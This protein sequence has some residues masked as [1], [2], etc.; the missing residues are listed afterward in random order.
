MRAELV[1]TGTELLLGQVVNTNA[2]FL[3][4][5]LA[6]LGI[7][8]YRVTTVGDNLARLIRALRNAQE[9]ADLVFIGGG[10]G[11]TQDDLTREAVAEA[12][13]TR[14]Y[15]NEAAKQSILDFFARR[16]SPCP[17]AN[18]KQ[19]L[20]PEGAE[21]IPNIYG[22]APGF[23]LTAKDKTLIA[24][25][26]PPKEFQAMLNQY[27][28]PYLESLS[29]GKHPIIKSRIIRTCGIGESAAEQKVY[30][31]VQSS[32][33]T[34]APLVTIGEVH[35]RITAK[36][37][38]AALAEALIDDMDRKLTR[39]LEGYIY[40]RDEVTLEQ[41]TGWLLA[42][43]GLT[44]AT[45]ESCTG[46]LLS[47]RITNVPGS[48]R[49]FLFGT[50]AYDNRFKVEVLKVDPD[51]IAD[52]GAVSSEVAEQMARGV[53][54]LAGTDFG[55][56]ITGIAGPEGG[57]PEKPVGL[58][59]IALDFRGDTTVRRVQFTGDRLIIKEQAAQAALVLLWR[60]LNCLGT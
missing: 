40:G 25:P 3:L 29:P 16:N 20:L 54:T 1:F 37:E 56:G 60:K 50:T 48:S 53:R 38:T 5:T 44:L 24:L 55:V 10:L 27:V 14:L 12:T 8:V 2:P 45:A 22:T 41:A 26:G 11:P 39:R 23:I 51:I 9:S 52:K 32:N 43:K 13:G 59:Y 21:I 49:Y 31:L 15:E 28:I 19:A 35:F 36:A 34:V 30:D 46:G 33:P 6:E 42:E 58:V 4:R 17:P 47:H 57:T 18:L 7:E